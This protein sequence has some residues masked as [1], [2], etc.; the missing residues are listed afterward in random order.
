MSPFEFVFAMVSVITS[1]ALVQIVTGV[2]ELIRHHDRHG[3]SGLHMLW[4]ATAFALVVSNWASFW[5]THDLTQWSSLPVFTALISMVF[6]YGF[7]ALVIPDQSADRRTDFSTF[8]E[9]EGRR[10]ITA[11]AMFAATSLIWGL[12]Y[13]GLSM[14]ALADSYFGI[15]ALLLSG[16]ALLFFKVRSIQWLV[17]IALLVTNAWMMWPTIAISA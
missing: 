2:V 5:S 3:F 10:Y 4:V 11:H 14:K 17:A 12:A 8:H 6:L 1:L 13:Y 9:R 16:V 7:T 15:F